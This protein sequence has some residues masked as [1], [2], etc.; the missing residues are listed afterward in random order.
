M[1]STSINPQL[2]G[3]HVWNQ[4]E[5]YIGHLERTHGV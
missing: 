5:L 3:T 2:S 4:M 1:H